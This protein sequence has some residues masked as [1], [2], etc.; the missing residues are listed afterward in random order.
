MQ[1][2]SVIDEAGSPSLYFP[3]VAPGSYYVVVYHRNHLSVMSSEPVNLSEGNGFWD[4][5]NSLS[6]AFHD[7]LVD[8]G[9]GFFGLAGGDATGDGHVTAPDF[10]EWNAK[11]TSGAEGYEIVDYDMDGFV[12]A[13][14][15]NMWNQNTASGQRSFVPE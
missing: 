2:G 15:F 6:S 1:D 7:G 9:G 13:P 11:T 3:D 12:T 4:F 8:L 14:D 10:N 5:R